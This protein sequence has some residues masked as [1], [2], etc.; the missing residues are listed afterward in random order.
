MMISNILWILLKSKRC[1][2]TTVSSYQL[3]RHARGCLWLFKP[4]DEKEYLYVEVGEITQRFWYDIN[5]EK[6]WTMVYS[7]C[8][9]L[10]SFLDWTWIKVGLSN[11]EIMYVHAIKVEVR[12]LDSDHNSFSYSY[13]HS[14]LFA[15]AMHEQQMT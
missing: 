10:F 11:F 12:S 7:F 3:M 1:P 14:H 6:L 2:S 5:C 8:S 15:V 9:S 13:V 4:W